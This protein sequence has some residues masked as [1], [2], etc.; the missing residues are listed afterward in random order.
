[1]LTLQR[2]IEALSTGGVRAR[3]LIEE[4]LA[5]IAE[6]SGQGAATFLHV[7][8]AEARALAESVDR[9]RSAGARLPPLAGVPVSVKDLFDIAGLATAA[10]SKVLRARA[11]ASR[12]A[13][14]VER[15]RAAGMIVIGRT[16]MTELA[17]SG[18]GIN[19][20]FGTPL[21]PY[22]RAVGRIP[23]GSSSGAAVSVTDGMAAIGIGSDT[24]GSVRIPAALTGLAGF[25]P[26]AERIP[27]RGLAPLSTTLDSVGWMGSS[28]ACCAL[29]DSLLSAG[30]LEVPAPF[31]LGGLRLLV[32]QSYVLDDLDRAVGVA[33]ERCL[34]ALSRA[35]ALI[36]EAPLPELARLPEINSKGGFSAAES[37]A[38]YGELIEAHPEAFDP[39]VAVRV[40]KGREQTAVDYLRV[41]R[42]RSELIREV[43]CKTQ[44]FDAVVMPTVPLL[45]PSL[46]E[47]ASDAAY[48]R[49][50]A[51]VLRN[52]A[53]ANFLDGCAI[54]VPVHRAGEAPVGLML[55]GEHGRDRRLL[56][57]A[58][59]V[60][61]LLAPQPSS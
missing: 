3:D 6:P 61:S 36:V 60:E 57:L 7:F 32:P 11:A 14:V 15:V 26:T 46:E 2:L 21:N 49:A 4:C 8:A 42:A 27:R 10:G 22:D 28:V 40:L 59:S 43:G 20:H 34:G 41:L 12:D 50:N 35:G 51:R 33:F 47:L 58:R 29:L 5:R 37:Y 45:A 24:G 19:P 56:A 25:K 39:R 38:E 1:M 18:L 31:S 16:N 30:E 44:A 13:E 53:I 9:L 48:F 52:P 23:G 17:F 55:M 54:S